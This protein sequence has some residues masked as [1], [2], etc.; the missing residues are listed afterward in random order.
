MI[1]RT[2]W[3]VLSAFVLGAAIAFAVSLLRRPP[4]VE[5]GGLVGGSGGPTGLSGYDA[6]H[7]PDGPQAA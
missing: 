2:L 4:R 1:R 5:A 6:P 7:P 3:A